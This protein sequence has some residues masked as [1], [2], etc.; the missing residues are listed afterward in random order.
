V[1]DKLDSGISLSRKYKNAFKIVTLEGDI[2]STAGSITGGSME[3][4]RSGILSRSRELLQL[5]TDIEKLKLEEK[6]LEK[7]IDELIAKINKASSAM[8]QLE[9]EIKDNELIKI[10]DESDLAQVEENISK[11]LSKVEML[12]Q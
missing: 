11:R 5:K 2:I 3:N 1:V 4:N 12:K 9:N 6:Q 8:S 7:D 10:R